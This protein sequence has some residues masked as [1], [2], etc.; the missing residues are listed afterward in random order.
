VDEDFYCPSQDP[1]FTA[2]SHILDTEPPRPLHRLRTP[3]VLP[4]TEIWEHLFPLFNIMIVLE[5]YGVSS[6]IVL[7]VSLFA[8]SSN[9]T[10]PSFASFS[11]EMTDDVRV[12]PGKVMDFAS[13]SNGHNSPLNIRSDE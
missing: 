13:P 8:P 5:V 4:S 3:P 7:F 1:P 12:K 11:V 10:K 9:V 2:V 6:I